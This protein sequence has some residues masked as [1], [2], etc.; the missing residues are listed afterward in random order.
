MESQL[1]TE[2]IKIDSEVSG[3][4]FMMPFQKAMLQEIRSGV[5]ILQDQDNQIVK[6]AT[7]LF[8][9]IRREQEA[10][11]KRISNHSLQILAVKTSNQTIQQSLAMVTLRIDEVIKAMVAITTWSKDMPTKRELRQSQ[12]LMEDQL[13][14]AEN[15]NTGL[16]TAM[17][18]Y[19]VSEST[20]FHVE[21]AAEPSGTQ[22]WMHPQR[23]AAM[24]RL[25]TSVSSLRYT[26]SEISWRGLLRGG[27]GSNGGQDGGA[28]KGQDGGA[29]GGQDD[30]AAGG[31]DSG[32]AKRQD[33]GAAG[34]QDDGA[35]GGQD[36]RAAGGLGGNGD[37]PPDTS[38]HGGATG[39]RML[40]RRRR[41]EELEFAKPIKIREPKRFEGK[42]GDDCDTWWVLVK[43]CIED[44]PE[45]FPKDER[46]IDWIGSLMDR[47]AAA[48]HIQWLEGTMNGT[49]PKSMTG[50]INALMLRFEDRDAKGETYADLENVQYEGCIRDMITKIQMYND[51]AL[52]SGAAFKK[53]I[54][55]QLPQKIL[56]QM[57][58]VDLTGK[59]DQQ[60]INIITNAG[61]TAEKW[62]VARKNLGL[63][64]SLGSQERSESKHGHKDRRDSSKNERG[65]NDK[66]KK[67][68]FK[69][70]DR[71]DRKT[72]K[73]SEGI[74]SS[75]SERMKAAGEC[76]RCAW[77]SH[78]KGSHGVKDCKR[79]IKLDKETASYLKAKEYQ[80]IKLAG[81]Q[82]DNKE[83]D[84]SS[85]EDS[86]T[87]SS[88]EEDSDTDSGS[89]EDENTE[90]SDGEVLV[91]SE[92]EMEEYREEKNWWDSDSDSD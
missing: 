4:G 11:S 81:M 80:K 21:S 28:A 39:R 46:T 45:N 86:D 2:K 17:E 60:I 62:D 42:P 91:N 7:D 61:R 64:V 44:Q 24:G 6:E 14:Q 30:G 16:T 23:M 67:D 56:E 70:K 18:A 12:C 92:K 83:M 85:E 41:I 78:R 50:H 57:H 15:I 22:N 90:D 66:F 89:E 27:A 38:D 25:S 58:T 79:P 3:V 33:G 74:D 73:E 68:W 20:P 53:L 84:S 34:G 29:A 51:E 59:T 5:H 26:V 63:K 65:S 37:P 77:P 35:A 47:Y 40:R 32:A 87:D 31:Q 13:A 48:W 19:K 8:A 9:V 88:S 1:Q 43:V 36:C 10:M 49:Y 54:L 55:E 75:E 69:N 52:V 82:M 76:L 72:Y 71:S